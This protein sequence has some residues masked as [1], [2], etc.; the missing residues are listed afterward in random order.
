MK[1]SITTSSKSMSCWPT[2]RRATPAG[3]I[4]R[5]VSSSM[6]S[7]SRWR[8]CWRTSCSSIR[9]CP[10]A[11]A[12]T[13]CKTPSAWTS[14]L[15]DGQR[16]RFTAAR[17]KPVLRLFI[18]LFDGKHRGDHR[19]RISRLDAPRLE[20]LAEVASTTGLRAVEAAA[21]RLRGSAGVAPV[22]VPADLVLTLRP[23]QLEGLSWLQHLRAHDLG[24]IL[25]DDMGLGKT[26]QTLAHLLIE[27]H[28]GR[29][30]RASL[31]VVP[32][33]L[34]FNWKREAERIAPTLSVLILHGPQRD[35]GA[36]LET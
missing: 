5:S 10:A 24:G 33:S 32:T 28:A 3:S 22:A 11:R 25:A 17:L 30:D 18:D 23:Y 8:R 16:V 27:K 36:I 7:A 26:V 34:V 21:A 20:A 14:R 2:C 13:A 31:V 6:A 29:L 15:E 9:T 4:Y 19:L 12:S 1:A 35:F